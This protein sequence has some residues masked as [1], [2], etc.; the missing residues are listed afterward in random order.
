MENLVI[1]NNK[2]LNIFGLEQIS[3]KNNKIY[4]FNLMI[5]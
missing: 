4:K 2:T 3:M 5:L 1:K